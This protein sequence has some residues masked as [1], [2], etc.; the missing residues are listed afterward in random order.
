MNRLFHTCKQL[1]GIAA[2]SVG[3]YACDWIHDDSLPLC[4]FRL[5][6]KYDYNMKFA[7]AF[8]HEVD[9]VT[10]F[11]CD[12][13]GNFLFQRRIEKS[14]LDE[15]NS[16]A[17]DME[18]GTYQVVT[19][20]GL[21]KGSYAWND[22]A[23]T[24]QAVGRAQDVKV[25]TLREA[26]TTQPNEL[27][28]LWHSLDTFTV[29]RDMPEADTISLAK[30]TNKLRVVLQNV[31]GEDMD[32]NN[33]SFRIVADNGYMDYDNSLL[34]DP[35]IHY[36]PYY[37]EN[38]ELGADPTPGATVGG[39]YVA[40]AEMNTMRLMAGRN[41]RL[42]I[43]HHGWE[44]DV[45]NVN[46]NDYLL[47]TKMEGHRISPQ[48]YL[49]R[50]DEYSIIFFL[51]PKVCPDCPDKPTPPDP[52]DPSGP[53]NADNPDNPDNPDGPDPEDPTIVGYACFKIQVKDWVIRINDGI[54]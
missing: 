9:F 48:E 5:Y 54:L 25:R 6:F 22:P 53:D 35:T 42:I 41:Y 28:P 36:L 15:R 2:L 51:T 12:Q 52:P 10:L 17:L 40:V 8:Q 7:D 33:F 26:N 21:D 31:M 16:I 4:E 46:L 14:E 30:N 11:F 49:D 50:Q 24:S 47:L 45:L 13:E 43:R 20:A 34:Q 44:K 32:V 38:V 27:H 3:L 37:T 18:P 23:E 1:I 19:W 29:T 39:Q